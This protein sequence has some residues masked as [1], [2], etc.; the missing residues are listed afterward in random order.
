MTYKLEQ[1][2]ISLLQT[3]NCQLDTLYNE[4]VA[5]ELREIVL[6]AISTGQIEKDQL[7]RLQK[8]LLQFDTHT[9]ESP[10]S[11]S[12]EEF[13]EEWPEWKTISDAGIKRKILYLHHHLSNWLLIQYVV[14]QKQLMYKPSKGINKI[15]DPIIGIDRE[16]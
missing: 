16:H 11:D 9:E 10:Q 14:Y 2:E 15:L 8:L 6:Q 5:K 7:K 1:Y 3:I 4:T 13:Y 12:D